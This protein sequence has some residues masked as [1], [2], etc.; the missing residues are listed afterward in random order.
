MRQLPWLFLLVVAGE[1]VIL[2]RAAA[3]IGDRGVG[4]EELGLRAVAPLGHVVAAASRR[5]AAVVTPFRTRGAL[6]RENEELRREV[7]RQRLELLR[8]ETLEEE[9]ERLAAAVDYGRAH[10]ALRFH[11]AEVIY[12]DYTSWLRT[13]LV[14]SSGATPRHNQGVVSSEGVVGRVVA[15]AGGYARVQLVL[16]RSAAVGAELQR[17]ER[18]GVV[19]GDGRGGLAMDFVPRQVDVQALDLVVT[20][21]IDGVF[22]PG[23]PVGVVTAVRPGDGELFHHIELAPAVDFGRLGAVYL[24]DQPVPPA[25]LRSDP[26][27]PDGT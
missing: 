7:E 8:R 15:A 9:V 16:D 13:L 12:A 17:T 6:L 5:G 27:V 11:V 25:E 20:A 10:G 24:L 19:R 26:G 22:P 14:R 1:L 4:L 3:S 21:G 23:L 18:Q 2:A